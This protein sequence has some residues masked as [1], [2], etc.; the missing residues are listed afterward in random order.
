MSTATVEDESGLLR[1][2]RNCWRLEHAR[3]VSFLVDGADYFAA[4]RAAAKRAEQ[5]IFIIGWDIDSRIRLVP[6][7]AGDGLPEALGEFLN[8]LVKRRRTLRIFVLDWDF[9]MLFAPERELLPI[10]KLGWR[11]HRRLEFRLDDAH[12]V[13]ACHHQKIVV[14]DDAVAFVGGIDLTHCRW[15]TSEHRPDEP[16]R[17][18]PE[19]DA[20]PPFHDVQIA[21][22]GEAAAALGEL[23]RER[24]RRATGRRPRRRETS[25][26][27]PWPPGLAADLTD[28]RVAIARTEPPYDSSGGVQEIKQL[29]LD[30]I[31]AVRHGL[32]LENQYFSAGTIA[33]AL[34]G[35][36][37]EREGPDVVLVSRRND[38]GW[39]EEATMG[40]LRARLHR[41]L[42]DADRHGR[43][44][45]FYPEVRG[46]GQDFINVHSKLLI[47][48][49]ELLTI[50]SA[51]LSNRS[52]GL[53]TECNLAI[54]AAGD[55]R[56]G[57]AIRRLRHR[58]LAEHLGQSIDTVDA[59]EREASSWLVAIEAL[60]GH[61]RS[62]APLEP[63]IDPELDRLV[64]EGEVVDP[65]RP[66]RP[67]QL[68]AEFVPREAQASVLRRLA[69]AIV[70]L[71]GLLALAAVWR[72]T[73]LGERVDLDALAAMVA[74]LRDAPVAPV[75]VLGAY[76]VAG[77][78]VVPVTA[79]VAATVI[80]FG[81]WLGLLYAAGGALLSAASTYMLGRALGR[82][83]M[84]RLAGP[85]LNRL[86]RRLGR[87]GLIAVVAVRLIPIAPF[88]I[89]NMVAGATHIGMRDFLLGTLLGMAP[90][91][92]ATAFFVDR[93]AAAVRD[94]GAGTFAV[95][96]GLLVLAVAAAGALRRWVKG[97]D[98][99]SGN[100]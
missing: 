81:P 41:R 74:T 40:V 39:L 27:D 53:D 88:T 96:A 77:L 55:E 95:L 15:D 12:P 2:G 99:D 93:V 8:A 63:E 7:G 65:E 83:T 90:G 16:R 98:G 5:S 86:S 82:D 35:R 72:W 78:L 38:S 71:A 21:V 60:R 6:D 9:A 85:R 59:K 46:L 23:A 3:R 97:M 24:W 13:G 30:A 33:D 62:L 47:M 51:N 66:V 36:L 1:P 29:Y 19:G 91:I 28:A 18:H 31:G 44:R 17:R 11:T 4:V 56:V 67:D 87:R 14:V 64:P 69:P 70:L 94:P 42:R 75:A 48:D 32:Y 76:V 49:D 80:V 73:S 45:C 57:A 92:L 100:R 37:A 25:G 68:V 34:A 22:D 10:Y 52:F 61:P 20:C 79:M 26:A 84:R 50:G 89:V 58:L 54:E 43:Y